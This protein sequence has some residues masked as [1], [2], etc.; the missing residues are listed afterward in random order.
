M[1]LLLFLFL[2]PS[3][4]WSEEICCPHQLGNGWKMEL[5]AA[6]TGLNLFHSLLSGWKTSLQT[7][8]GSLMC[9][10]CNHSKNQLHSTQQRCFHSIWCLSIQNSALGVS[11]CPYNWF[12][13][14]DLG[15]CTMCQFSSVIIWSPVE[16]QNK[17]KYSPRNWRE[18]THRNISPITSKP[19]RHA[20]K[21]AKLRSKRWKAF[22]DVKQK[23]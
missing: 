1:E 6:F 18:V 14:P 4:P 7:R 22:K 5:E 17:N 16:G 2:L 20:L 23:V 13:H 12:R 10:T 9:F 11:P 3:K 15:A 8:M 19:S 21:L